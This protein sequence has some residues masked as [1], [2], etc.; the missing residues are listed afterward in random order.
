M[1][2]NPY[3][4]HCI[5]IEDFQEDSYTIKGSNNLAINVSESLKKSIMASN[6]VYILPKK[7]PYFKIGDKVILIC[8]KT[9]YN[10]V[11]TV[12]SL[13]NLSNSISFKRSNLLL[14]FRAF[15]PLLPL[16]FL[17]AITVMFAPRSVKN[18][19]GLFFF[20]VFLIIL[21]FVVKDILHHR[22]ATKLA[23]NIQKTPQEAYKVSKLLTLYCG[24]TY[25]MNNF[26]QGS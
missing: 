25:I 2:K 13:F 3:I 26:C 21:F 10:N 14:A 24:E 8:R 9:K 19:A 22:K 1:F 12:I 15:L 17:I 18:N 23:L 6:N 4:V 20:M 11:Y 5:T 7:L 16:Q